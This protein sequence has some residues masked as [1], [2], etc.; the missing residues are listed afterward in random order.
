MIS[1]VLITKI[2]KKKQDESVR[3]KSNQPIPYSAPT[4]ILK[5]IKILS[6]Y[7]IE[8]VGW[9]YLTKALKTIAYNS[10]FIFIETQ[11]WTIEQIK[12]SDSICKIPRKDSELT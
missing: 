2:L 6:R 10:I 9:K 11:N 1:P 3:F 7:T 8:V 12:I 5:K 4:N